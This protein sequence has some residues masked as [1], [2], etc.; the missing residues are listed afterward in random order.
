MLDSLF[1]ADLSVAFWVSPINSS[2]VSLVEPFLVL[3]APDSSES[4][5]EIVR[6]INEW[7]ASST[8]SLIATVN[9]RIAFSE[10]PFSV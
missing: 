7:V 2:I 8:T 9:A 3:A 10:F 5:V 1:V 6:G 4:I